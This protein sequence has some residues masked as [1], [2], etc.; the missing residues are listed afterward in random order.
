MLSA[1]AR[2]LRVLIFVEATSINGVAKTILTFCDHIAGL[3]RGDLHGVL[4]S[5]VTFHRD[6]PGWSHS[7]NEFVQAV[8]KRGLKTYVIPERG[9]FDLKIFSSIH[10]TIEDAI[11]D[12]IQTNSVKS[13]FLIK[14]AGV[15]RSRPWIAFHH[16]YTA[17]DLKMTCYNQ[18]DR[19]SLRSADRVVI[20]CRAFKSQ[21]LAAGV[22]DER[23]CILHNAADIVTGEP[24]EGAMSLRMRLG[25]D[26]DARFLLAV[27]RMSYEK[28]QMDLIHAVCHMW[29]SSPQLKWKLVLVGFGPEQPKLEAEVRR[30][31][32][33]SRV[34]LASNVPDVLPFYCAADIFVLPSHSEGCPHVIFEAMA[35]GVPIVATCA[36]G[37]PEILTHRET[38]V[39]TPP[40]QPDLLASAIASLLESPLIA[41]AYACK[42]KEMLRSRFSLDAYTRSLLGIYQ[43]V[44]R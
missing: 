1:P 7:R 18:L 20:P 27:G 9:R 14:A 38:A 6:A 11:P 2:P 13:H 5:I 21:L 19:W 37:I 34:V 31:G 36:G 8:R 4:V 3:H 28:G 16:G 41:R 24:A 32:L 17:T 26:R 43:E 42:A 12:I 22:S 23:I 30:L 25:I 15:H 33:Q 40:R 39:L 29:R 35:A 44:L 10:Q